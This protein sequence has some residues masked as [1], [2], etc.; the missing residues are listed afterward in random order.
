M[1]QIQLRSAQLAMTSA[2]QIR[3]PM[4]EERDPISDQLAPLE[5]AAVDLRRL[6]RNTNGRV[7]IALMIIFAFAVVQGYRYGYRTSDYI[8]LI[9]ASAVFY[10]VMCFYY[11]IMTIRTHSQEKSQLAWPYLIIYSGETALVMFL[12]YIIGYRG[13]WSLYGLK[14]GF[15][16]RPIIKTLVFV[17]IG[18]SALKYL[19]DLR[20]IDRQL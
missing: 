16:F 19:Y 10:V 8:F 9:S 15:S 5:K 7:L 1:G 12:L 2:S 20:W 14:D 17:W 6:I 13:L 18:C 3:A 11:V 4:T